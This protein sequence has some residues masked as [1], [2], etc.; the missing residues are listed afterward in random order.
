MN[1]MRSGITKLAGIHP[2]FHR[3]TPIQGKRPPLGVLILS[4]KFSRATQ[5]IDYVGGATDLLFGSPAIVA[6]YEG[7]KPQPTTGEMTTQFRL[8]AFQ[9]WTPPTT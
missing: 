8:I 1:D 4:I 3:N 9:A 5:L 6:T 2:D 7:F